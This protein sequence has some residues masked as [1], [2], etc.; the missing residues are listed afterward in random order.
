MNKVCNKKFLVYL[1][2]AMYQE[3]SL[4][5]LCYSGLVLLGRLLSGQEVESL[6]ANEAFL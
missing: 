5:K 6:L 3:F 2:D 1:Q 4:Y